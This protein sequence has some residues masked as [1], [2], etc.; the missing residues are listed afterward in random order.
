MVGD[1]HA[2]RK[3]NKSIFLVGFMASGKSTVGPA[4][5]GILNLPFV[6]I[7]REIEKVVGCSIGE[8]IQQQG[9]P[10]FR[11]LETEYL[12]KYAEAEIAVIALGGGAFTFAENRTVVAEKGIS[13]W[14]DAPFELCWARI[15]QDAAIRP[16]AANEKVALERFE[17]RRSIYQL[18]VHRV[19]IKPDETSVN[20]AREIIQS[21]SVS[22]A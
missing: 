8:L 4:L 21:I 20:I 2:V 14:L 13:V 17:A 5:A 15:Q 1:L 10:C 6:D 12:R 9:E 7:D 16:L 18:A 11:Q 19:T 22:A 3:I